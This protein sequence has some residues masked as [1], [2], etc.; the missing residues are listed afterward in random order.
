MSLLPTVI[1]FVLASATATV[2]VLSGIAVAQTSSGE[3]TI[4]GFDLL[5]SKRIGRTTFEYEYGVNVQNGT[6]TDVT[7]VSVTVSSS[8]PGVTVLDDSALIGS[9]ASGTTATSGDTI[10]VE[11]DRRVRFDPNNLDFDFQFSQTP[12]VITDLDERIALAVPENWIGAARDDS[13]LLF[14]SESRANSGAL[15]ELRLEIYAFDIDT[16]GMD[17]DSIL[18]LALLESV[19]IDNIRSEAYDGTGLLAHVFS[20]GGD[21]RYVIFDRS[22]NTAVIFF[23]HNEALLSGTIFEQVSSSIRFN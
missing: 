11:V 5:S 14:S 21:Y 1:R 17:I 2:M 16:S 3:V 22:S 12:A 15:P 4:A 6:S 7:D 18:K 10:T 13:I 20:Y 23:A 19:E 8:T 9:I